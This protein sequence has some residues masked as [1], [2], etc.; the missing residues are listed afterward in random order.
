MSNHILSMTDSFLFFLSS[1][2]M[3]M[4]MMIHR[5]L[6][7]SYFHLFL[8]F[9]LDRLRMTCSFLSHFYCISKPDFDLLRE[10]EREKTQSLLFFLPSNEGRY[11]K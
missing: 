3:I 6:F 5:Y 11:K 8:A 4:M 2:V 10:R 1:F 7:K 9:T